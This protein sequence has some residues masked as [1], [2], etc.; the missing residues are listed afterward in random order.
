MLSYFLHY[1]LL[2]VSLCWLIRWYDSLKEPVIWELR[3]SGCA[4]WFWFTKRNRLIRVICSGIGRARSVNGTDRHSVLVT[5]YLKYKTG[6]ELELVG[7][8]KLKHPELFILNNNDK[9]N[10]KIQSYQDL[11]SLPL[12]LPFHPVPEIQGYLENP[13]SLQKD[14]CP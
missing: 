13:A 5:L 11:L 3:N 8:H 6:S 1:I 10:I 12:S 7:S 2:R 4:I 9:K 14:K